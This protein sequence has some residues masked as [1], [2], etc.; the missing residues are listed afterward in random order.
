MKAAT[1]AVYLTLTSSTNLVDCQNPPDVREDNVFT[2][3]L[4]TMELKDMVKLSREEALNTIIR[5][6]VNSDELRR[7]F[8]D[9]YLDEHA[10]VTEVESEKVRVHMSN[11]DNGYWIHITSRG[12]AYNSQ[13]WR[14]YII[15]KS[16]LKEVVQEL[17]AIAIKAKK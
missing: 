6:C 14:K 3:R 13:N 1:L 8:S 17:E 11:R 4:Y 2:V 15:K 9:S 16:K 12:I 10:L 7:I 5:F